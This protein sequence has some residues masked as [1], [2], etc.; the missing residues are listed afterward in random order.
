[1]LKYL[2]GGLAVLAV[3]A[4][5]V[6]AAQVFLPANP[7]SVTGNFSFTPGAV[8]F[9]DQA[10]FSLSGGP[11]YLTIANATNVYASEADRIQNWVASIF[12]AGLDQVVNNADDVLL[13]GPQAAQ[14]CGFPTNC[15][16]VG[17]EGTIFTS[18]VFYA[19]FTGTGSGTSGYS[20]NISTSAVP[21][22]AVGAGLPGI[23]AAFG[24]A[25]AWHR[26]KKKI[27]AAKLAVA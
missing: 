5:P 1:M 16:I 25:M 19:E 11:Q 24:A 8:G 7:T 14:A 15:Q 21:L 20:G 12:S 18:G 23:I 2:L 10:I 17:G 9:E 4:L 6:Q 26:R 13:F 27:A 3:M 22:P